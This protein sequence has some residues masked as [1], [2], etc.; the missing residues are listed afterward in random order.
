MS[1]KDALEYLQKEVH[2]HEKRS[3]EIDDDY[4]AIME[5]IAAVVLSDVMIALIKLELDK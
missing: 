4:V 2:K 1:I 5:A 3:K